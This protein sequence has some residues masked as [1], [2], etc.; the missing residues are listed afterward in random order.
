MPLK[1]S[2]L[3]GAIDDFNAAYDDAFGDVLPS[4]AD[5]PFKFFVRIVA[6]AETGVDINPATEFAGKRS[7]LDRLL[8]SHDL[9][10]PRLADADGFEFFENLTHFYVE[11]DS[12]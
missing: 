9:L 10:C 3:T 8:A 11:P 6:L 7:I 12:C 1:I 5:F 4:K 2:F